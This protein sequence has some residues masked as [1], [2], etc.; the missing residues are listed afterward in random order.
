MDMQ[1]FQTTRLDVRPMAAG[2]EALYRRLYSDPE[3]MR[4]IGTPL[5]AEAAARAFAAALQLAIQPDPRLRVWV[6]LERASAGGVGILALIGRASEEALEWGAMLL[7]R[8]QGRGFAV[9]ANAALLDRLFATTGISLVWCR[10][11]ERNEAAIRAR[12]KLGFLESD[13]TAASET[14]VRWQIS[15]ELWLAQRQ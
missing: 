8:G 3:V 15:R 4:H 6:L 5:T 9:E 14:G 10:S 11:S 1:P 12:T 7:P 2:D 13:P